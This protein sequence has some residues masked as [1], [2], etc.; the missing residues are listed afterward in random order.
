MIEYVKYHEEISEVLHRFPILK[1]FIINNEYFSSQLIN[2]YVGYNLCEHGEP[3][4][5]ALVNKLLNIIF[6]K[7]IKGV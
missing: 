2:E 3:V 4:T 1:Q 5:S 7:R 6:E